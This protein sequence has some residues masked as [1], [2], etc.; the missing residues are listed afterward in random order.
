M[1]LPDDVLAIIRDYSKPVT[2]PDWRTIQPLSGHT[3]YT[4]IYHARCIQCAHRDTNVLYKRVFDNLKTSNWGKMY[5]FIRLEG[6]QYASCYFKT[7]VHE[8][9]K[10]PGIIDAQ[11]YYRRV[12]KMYD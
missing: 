11:D 4:E 5:T 1:Q 10:M 12:N 8:L 6:I 9:Y 7:H 2:R 3:F